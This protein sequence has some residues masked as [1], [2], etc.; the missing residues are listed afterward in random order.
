MLFP[1]VKELETKVRDDKDSGSVLFFMDDGSIIAP[2]R[3]MSDAISCFKTKGPEYGLYMRKDK[4]KILLGEC[5]T[6]AEAMAHKQMYIDL[7]TLSP[8]D[9]ECSENFGGDF[10]AYI[11][12]CI[13]VHPLN[14]PHPGSAIQLDSAYGLVVLGIPIGS[15][16]Y[17][18]K[19]LAQKLAA[20]QVEKHYL[21]TIITSHHLQ[22]C[23]LFHCIRTKVNHFFRCLPSR[24]TKNLADEFDSLLHSAMESNI[25]ST[26]PPDAWVQLKLN[27]KYGG[28]GLG[29]LDIVCHTAFL[30]STSFVFST[31]RLISH[32]PSFHVESSPRNSSWCSDIRSSIDSFNTCT[33]STSVQLNFNYLL[34][35]VNRDLQ[36]KLTE[37]LDSLHGTAFHNIKRSNIEKARLLSVKSTETS[38]FLQVTPVHPKYLI[39]NDQWIT[40]NSNAS[41]LYVCGRGRERHVAHDN[42]NDL[43]DEMCG[44]AGISTILEPY[45]PESISMCRADLRLRTPGFTDYDN[46][47]ERPP[48]NHSDFMLDVSITYPGGKTNLNIHKSYIKQGISGQISYNTKRAQALPHCQNYVFLPLIFETFGQFHYSFFFL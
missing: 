28:H 33:N 26:I 37:I 23:L 38:A 13:K 41:H 18:K 40:I 31:I 48:G 16:T 35:I 25:E 22:W 19:H 10:Q 1:L 3:F 30:A 2:H 21:F 42:V 7:L 5:V 12:S 14:A 6:S 9:S 44:Q 36:H 24:L 39:W 8:T 43:V 47:R 17:I 11:D 32:D 27:R 45:F 15:D 46:L 29:N 20:I 4:T 34:S